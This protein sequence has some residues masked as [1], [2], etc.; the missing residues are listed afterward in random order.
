MHENID[1]LLENQSLK[2]E[3]VIRK[4]DL[5]QIFSPTP[6]NLERENK[7]LLH[8]LDWVR[9][10]SE[11]GDRKIMESEGFDFPPIEPG[12]SPENDWYLFERWMSGKPIRKKI[13]D[14]LLP[15]QVPKN[16]ENLNDEEIISEMQKLTEHLEKNRILVE[17]KDDIPLPLVIMHLLEML[18]EQFEMINDGFWHLDGCSGYCPDCFQRPWCETGC[19]SC[20]QEDEEA[21]KMF[22]IDIVKRYVSASPVSLSIL[23]KIQAEKDKKLE[24]LKK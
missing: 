3:F 2:N 4:L 12:I 24:N 1:L 22:L 14:Y 13:K 19:E 21:G 11:C 23:Q 10:Y 17:F 7:F 8:L 5:F 20:W 6:D 18:D 16:I 9:R 15:Y